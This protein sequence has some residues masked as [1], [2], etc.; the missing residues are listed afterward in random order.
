[1]PTNVTEG[2]KGDFYPNWKYMDGGA[3]PYQEAGNSWDEAGPA[4]KDYKTY[5]Y[6]LGF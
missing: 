4:G 3:Q 2:P 6:H 1:M 5:D